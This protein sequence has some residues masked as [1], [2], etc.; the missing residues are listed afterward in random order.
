MSRTVITLLIYPLSTIV[1]D[2]LLWILRPAIKALKAMAF[3]LTRYVDV[4]DNVVEDGGVAVVRS[5]PA[6][7]QGS[8]LD[9]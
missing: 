4:L 8:T 1:P 9:A 3:K 5:G 7:L 6:D 2:K